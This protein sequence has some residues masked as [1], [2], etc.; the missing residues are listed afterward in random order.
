MELLLAELCKVEEG[1][2]LLPSRCNLQGILQPFKGGNTA[3]FAAIALGG[4]KTSR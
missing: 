4:N 3:K 1:I 2:S